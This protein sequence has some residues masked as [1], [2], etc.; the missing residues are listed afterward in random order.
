MGRNA[1]RSRIGSDRRVLV[2]TGLETPLSLHGGLRPIDMCK[3]ADRGMV[4]TKVRVLEKHGGKS[5][6]WTAQLLT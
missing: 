4:M 6:D 3:A 5:G 2:S 1:L